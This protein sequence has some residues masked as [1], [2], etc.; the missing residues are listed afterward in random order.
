MAFLQK[1]LT[2]GT[3][4]ATVYECP[5]TLSGSVHGL[6]FTNLTGDAQLITVKHFSQLTGLTTTISSAAQSVP[7]NSQFTWPKPINMVAGDAVIA[8]CTNAASVVAVVSVYLDQAASPSSAFVPR[9]VWS[10]L[11][12][13]AVNDVVRLGVN[14]YI[15]VADNLNSSPPSGNWMLSAE[16]VT[17]AVGT[18]TTGIAGSNAS[19]TNVGTNTEAV[20]NIT[21]PHGYD[22]EVTLAAATDIAITLSIALG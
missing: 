13:Y 18:V 1:T 9:G 21:I 5:V 20:F 7:L 4:D 8:S 2:L 22:G 17:V 19:V 10:A 11:A 3:V 14:S 12:N 16:G 15:A 6:V